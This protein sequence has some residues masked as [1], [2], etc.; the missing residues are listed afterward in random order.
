MRS[1]AALGHG[2]RRQHP[3]ASAADYP[4][5]FPASRQDYNFRYDTSLQLYLV[6]ESLMGWIVHD[7]MTGVVDAGRRR[8]DELDHRRRRPRR[9]RLGADRAA[10]GSGGAE[11]LP[12]QR[13]LV[14]QAVLGIRGE[15]ARPHVEGRSAAA[16]LEFVKLVE[17][18]GFP[19]GVVN[20]VT[21]F[22]K[23]AGMPLVEHPL[24]A[25]ITSTSPR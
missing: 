23:E 9:R 21:G 7:L 13:S 11:V 8:G 18:A 17:Q 22:G 2:E 6:G 14:G 25:K 24:T 10:E 1:A 15:V 12:R 16:A 19:A 5:E 3:F 4:K 20:V